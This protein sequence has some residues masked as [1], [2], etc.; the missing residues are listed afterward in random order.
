MRNGLSSSSMLLY[1]HRDCLDYYSIRD[2]EPRMATLTFTQLL[3]S[4]TST[5]TD[6]R[7]LILV[8]PVWACWGHH[9]LGQW[10]LY[11]WLQRKQFR[12]FCIVF[13]NRMLRALWN[14]VG[15]IYMQ[16]NGGKLVMQLEID[17]GSELPL[18]LFD[19]THPWPGTVAAVKVDMFWQS[20]YHLDIRETETEHERDCLKLLIKMHYVIKIWTSCTSIVNTWGLSNCVRGV[21]FV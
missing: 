14:V 2:R 10:V 13:C 6:M 12:V 15:P 11:T 21:Y 3:S 17:V 9:N 18:N 19:V 1:V 7:S 4:D 20:V 16:M 5:S 8:C